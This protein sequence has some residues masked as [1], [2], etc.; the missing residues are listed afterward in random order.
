MKLILSTLFVL[1]LF[2]KLSIA[3]ENKK[4][5]LPKQQIEFNRI[6][7][8]YTNDLKKVGFD[9]IRN[10]NNSKLENNKFYKLNSIIGINTFTIIKDLN[11]HFNNKMN[12]LLK[13]GNISNW[14][15]KIIRSDFVNYSDE[16]MLIIGFVDNKGKT[17]T[18]IK[19]D[20][21]SIISIMFRAI[22]KSI[23]RKHPLHKKLISYNEGDYV[24]ISGNIKPILYTN[25]RLKNKDWFYN[26][27]M[28]TKGYAIDNRDIM[29]IF[30]NVKI[31]LKSIK[32][33]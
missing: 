32:K 26:N 15:V 19:H 29:S 25:N 20:S 24:L 23:I 12:N 4:Y 21:L 14:I 2:T 5:N 33:Y 10:I 31:D 30:L 7:N 16:S 8:D 9:Y 13:D 22:N 17:F 11:K 1:S 28:L 6:F 27:I 3:N 18:L